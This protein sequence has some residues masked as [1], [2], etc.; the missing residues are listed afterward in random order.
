MITLQA[1]N[2][3]NLIFFLVMLGLMF[4]IIYQNIR[5]QRQEKKFGDN[6]KKGDKVIMKSG[7]HG[8]ILEVNE[9]TIVIETM[10]GKLQFERSAVSLE[11]SSKLNS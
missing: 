2:T 1:Q 8:R 4:F 9:T 5:K 7:L 10:A 11:Y 6:L 3:S